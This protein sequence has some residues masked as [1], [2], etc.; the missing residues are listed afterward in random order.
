MVASAMRLP[1]DWANR[2]ISIWSGRRSRVVPASVP[3]SEAAVKSTSKNSSRVSPANMSGSRR[4]PIRRRSAISVPQQ[5]VWAAPSAP[6]SPAGIWRTES[7]CRFGAG[8]PLRFRRRPLPAED[9]APFFFLRA[10]FRLLIASSLSASPLITAR[11]IQTSDFSNSSKS[12]IP[13]P[14]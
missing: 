12:D 14:P 10:A 2:Q 7:P 6:H 11:T 3:P 13:R 4:N 8:Y 1:I 9:P 5:V